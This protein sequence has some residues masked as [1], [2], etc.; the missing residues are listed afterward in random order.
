MRIVLDLTPEDL[1]ALRHQSRINRNVGIDPE[2]APSI[3]PALEKLVQAAERP[4]V[5]QFGLLVIS[6]GAERIMAERARQIGA[7]GYDSSHDAEHHKGELAMAAACYAAP[8]PIF[9]E[10][11]VPRS[12]DCREAFCPHLNIGTTKGFRDPWPWDEAYDKRRHHN[13]DRQLEIAGALIAAELDRIEGYRFEQVLAQVKQLNLCCGPYPMAD[14]LNIDMVDVR[15]YWFKGQ[16][17]PWW[18]ELVGP[19]LPDDIYFLQHD[20]DLGLG[21]VKDDQMEGVH[22]HSALCHFTE[23]KARALLAECWRVLQPGGKLEVIGLQ[24]DVHHARG[25]GEQPTATPILRDLGFSL[26]GIWFTSAREERTGPIENPPAD[27]DE[28]I[29]ICATKP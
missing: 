18:P 16:H 11:D 9:A 20:V 26:D 1:E 24:I 22:I 27:A 12:C 3:G 29:G 6:R 13:R 10:V 5:P 21:F 8:V 14:A 28:L 7:E 23:E 25:E 4:D 17:E 15:P 2:P 19:L